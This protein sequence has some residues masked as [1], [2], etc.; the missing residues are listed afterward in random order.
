LQTLDTKVL[1]AGAESAF[2]KRESSYEIK[3][4]S[5][6]EKII[7]CQYSSETCDEDDFFFFQ[8]SE[9]NGKTYGLQL[10]MF[11]GLPTSCKNPLSIGTGLTFL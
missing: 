1:L 8:N 2:L 11:V 7:S 4:T 5:M 10:E 6:R 9:F 3:K